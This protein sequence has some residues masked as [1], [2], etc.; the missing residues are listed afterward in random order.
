MRAE[1][2]TLIAH[3]QR[4]ALILRLQTPPQRTARPGQPC[5]K[6]LNAGIGGVARTGGREA[7][8]QCS[9]R[10]A[11]MDL[12]L[13]AI[14]DNGKRIDEFGSKECLGSLG[15]EVAE[16][17]PTPHVELQEFDAAVRHPPL[18]PPR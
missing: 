14:L 13:R 15:E 18:P 17:A 3:T 10:R 4:H 16:I 9:Q 8:L 2:S 7:H 1:R 11:P 5:R 6:H 12:R